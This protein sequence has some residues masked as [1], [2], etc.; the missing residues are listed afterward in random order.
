MVYLKDN[1]II[2]T[3]LSIESCYVEMESTTAPGET[4]KR[5]PPDVKYDR[6]RLEKYIIDNSDMIKEIVLE[7]LLKY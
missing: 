7:H 2:F 4:E 6:A 5:E 1:I 3:E